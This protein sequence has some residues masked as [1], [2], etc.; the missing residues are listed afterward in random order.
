[1]SPEDASA[2]SN[3]ARDGTLASAPWIATETTDFG[4]YDSINRLI[5]AFTAAGPCFQI[6]SGIVARATSSAS[7]GGSAASPARRA[8]YQSVQTFQPSSAARRAD[9][10]VRQPSVA[11]PGAAFG[12]SG[13][14]ESSAVERA[15]SVTAASASMAAV[16]SNIATETC[17]MVESAAWA[18]SIADSKA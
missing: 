11:Q 16:M 12:Q 3:T 6:S 15:S 8:S 2:N 1:M 14:P 9:F 18:A 7:F 5:S 10:N 13:L 17:A 4:G